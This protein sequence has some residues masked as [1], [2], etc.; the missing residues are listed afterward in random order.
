MATSV[1]YPSSYATGYQTGDGNGTA[2]RSL[3]RELSVAA[4]IGERVFANGTGTTMTSGTLTTTPTSG[5]VLIAVVARRADGIATNSNPSGWTQLTAGGAA[6]SRYL[7]VWWYRSTGVAGDKGSFQW[8]TA[9]GTGAWGIEL[10][11]FAG[12]AAFGDPIVGTA[13]TNQGAT[14]TPTAL[15]FAPSSLGEAP[16]MTLNCISVTGAATTVTAAF[17]GTGT[18]ESTTSYNDGTYGNL[19]VS[20]NDLYNNVGYGSPT[21]GTA[22]TLG[23]SRASTYAQIHLTGGGNSSSTANNSMAGINYNYFTFT[24]PGSLAQAYMVYDTSSIP[25][26][27]TVSSATIGFVA[28]A[29]A[30]GGGAATT[31]PANAALQIRY[32]GTSVSDVRGSNNSHWWLSPTAMAAKTL[33]ATYA[34]ASAWTDGTSYTLTSQAGF[35]G[36]IN[37]T[38]NTVLIAS[39]DDYATSTA[40]SSR[41]TYAFSSA[42]TD[43]PLTVVHSFLGTASAAATTTMTPTVSRK[44]TYARTIAATLT[45]TPAIAR[46]IAYARTIASSLDLTPTINRTVTYLR[47]VS[48]SITT[49]PVVARTISISRTIAATVATIPA[50]VTA[51]IPVIVGTPYVITIKVR[52]HL[53]IPT[54]NRLRTAVRS[55]LRLPEN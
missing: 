34:A 55:I 53:A 8:T 16:G 15:T 45:G 21:Y 27:N 6:G 52:D 54:M 36:S 31:D 12:S 44:I 49:T 43:A 26:N 51:V 42:G 13:A 22:F 7:E 19:G 24:R 14:T 1:F 47:T 11:R 20:I 17:S 30:I 3:A 29:T 37:K 18:A 40:R 41:E 10:I 28:K 5:D 32:Y 35:T 48:S 25:D 39:T 50:L 2:A 46:T 33:C 9:S 4:S 23:A 38:G